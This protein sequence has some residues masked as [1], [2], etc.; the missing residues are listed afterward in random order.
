MTKVA[1][2]PAA[3]KLPE[4]LS[5]VIDGEACGAGKLGNGQ[6][7]VALDVEEPQQSTQSGDPH[8]HDPGNHAAGVS[9]V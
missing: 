6:E 9:D 4:K 5:R 3:L 7:A 8:A 1:D 2:H